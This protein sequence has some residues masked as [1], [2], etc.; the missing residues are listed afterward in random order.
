M[1]IGSTKDYWRWSRGCAVQ[2]M[3][4][5]L[6]DLRVCL[7]VQGRYLVH[8]GVGEIWCVLRVLVGVMRPIWG[9][10]SFAIFAVV[11]LVCVF[12]LW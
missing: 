6:G 7:W 10:L 12:A 2:W 4:C 1:S 8:M 11:L 5:I 3:V 9:Y